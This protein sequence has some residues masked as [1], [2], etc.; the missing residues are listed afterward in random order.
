MLFKK[1]NKQNF[2]SL[3]SLREGIR[4]LQQIQ[5]YGEKLTPTHLLLMQTIEGKISPRRSQCVNDTTK[6]KIKIIIT[7]I[8]TVTITT[9]Q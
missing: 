6:L 5:Y 8:T 4:E 3:A 2:H 1:K 7:R 9:V